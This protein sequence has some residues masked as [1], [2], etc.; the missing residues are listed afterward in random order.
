M[1]DSPHHEIDLAAIDNLAAT[2]ADDTPDPFVNEPARRQE[3]TFTA[4]Q[5]TGDQGA[6]HAFRMSKDSTCGTPIE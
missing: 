1:L 5:W 2:L 4:A 3:P 6:S